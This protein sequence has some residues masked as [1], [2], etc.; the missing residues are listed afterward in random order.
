MEVQG[1]KSEECFAKVRETSQTF[2]DL[3]TSDEPEH[4]DCHILPY[5]LDIDQDGNVKALDAPMDCFPDTSA[6]ILGC[7]SFYL[8]EK[9]TT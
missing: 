6:P 2:W 4:S 8:P 7:K 9:L 1:I 5:P 3:Y